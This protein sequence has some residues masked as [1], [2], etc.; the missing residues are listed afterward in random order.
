MSEPS[1]RPR[2]GSN[3]PTGAAAF[4]VT[5]FTRLARAHAL[6]VAGDA[7]IAVALADSIFF[8]AATSEARGT[9][10]LYLLLTM[11]PFALVAPL[12]GPAI[13][14]ARGGRRWMIVGFGAVRCLVCV[15]MADDLNSLLL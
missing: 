6:S 2:R 10:A 4:V 1:P 11:A 3:K 12:I 9:T 7:L 13:D 15:F 5:P 8:S 14:R